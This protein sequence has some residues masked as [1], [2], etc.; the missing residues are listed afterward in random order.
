MAE[1]G[2]V[3]RY[4]GNEVELPRVRGTVGEVAVD[5]GD[6]RRETQLITLDN[7]FMNTAACESAITYVDGEQGMLLY[8][9]YPIEELAR[10]STFLEVAYLLLYGELPSRGELDDLADRI[11]HHTLLVEDMKRL[12]DAFPKDAHPMAILS[13]ATRALSSFYTDFLNPNDPEAVEES[14]LRLIAKLPT[15]AAFA[16]KKSLGQPYV[17]PR[18]DLYYTDNFLYMMFAVPSEPYEIDPLVA[19]TLDVLLVLHADHEQNLSTSTVRMVGSGGA[20]LFASISAGIDGLSGPAHGGANQAVVEM[21]ERIH[22]DG[23]NY[24]KYLDKAKDRKDRFRLTGFGH[25]VYKNFDPRAEIIKELADQVLDKLGSSDALLEIA[26]ELEQAALADDYF[27][28]RRLYPNVD[29]YSGIIYRA[30]GFPIRSFPVLFAIGRLPGWI[31][32]WR[33]MKADP[34]TKIGRP[35]QLYTGPKRREYVPIGER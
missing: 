15:I 11:I 6:L 14:A 29:F 27:V 30:I 1:D 34:A 31:A 10:D 24:Q 21:L 19:R 20:D 35:R 7:G 33:E 13:S 32:H 4:D 5:I 28:E 23:G 16:H 3:L 12:F 26:R 22:R 17:Y 8:R 25:R 2:V 18:N 9:G